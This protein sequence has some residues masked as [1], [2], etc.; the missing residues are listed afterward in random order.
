[1]Y[2]KLIHQWMH[3]G[4]NDLT[5]KINERPHLREHLDHL[6]HIHMGWCMLKR[7]LIR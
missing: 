6:S 1:M 4:K 2:T 7:I 5:R 3:I